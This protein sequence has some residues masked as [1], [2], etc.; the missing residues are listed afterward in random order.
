MWNQAT[1][2]GGGTV[3]VTASDKKLPSLTILKR[4]AK[5]GDVIPNTH[6]EIKGIHYGYHNDVTT[7]PDGRTVLTNIPV[8]SYEV[9]EKSVPDPYVVSGEPTQTIWLEAGD[10]KELI[11]DNQKQPLLKISKL[12]RVQASLSPAPSSSWRRLMGI[13]A[14]R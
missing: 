4:D 1:I 11:F 12:R 10:N 14:M 6:F 8:D 2:N 9:T 13:I 7:G 5:T 3:T